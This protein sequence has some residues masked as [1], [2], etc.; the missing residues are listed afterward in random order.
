MS[1]IR[2]APNGEAGL[3][4]GEVAVLSSLVDA[5]NR[6]GFY[7]AYNAMFDSSEAS[8]QSRIAT[9]SG[10]VGGVAFAANRILQVVFGPGTN[11]DPEYTGIYHLSQK[12]A[13]SALAAI[14]SDLLSPSNTDGSADGY[15][16]DG[17]FFD[18]ATAA[19]HGLDTYF[20]GNLLLE[21]SATIA[22]NVAEFAGSYLAAIAGGATVDEALQ[23]SFSSLSSPGIVASLLAT[24]VYSNFG[25]T[26]S[27]LTAEGYTEI[28]GPNGHSLLINGD[29]IVGA[30]IGVDTNDALVVGAATAMETAIAAG[31]SIFALNALRDYLTTTIWPTPAGDIDP[32]HLSEFYTAGFNGDAQPFGDPTIQAGMPV[33]RAS[34]T[35]GADIISGTDSFLTIGGND[36]INGLG[37]NDLIFGYGGEDTIDGGAGNDIIWGQAGDDVLHG[38]EGDDLLRGGPGNNQLFGDAGNDV[39]YGGSGTDAFDGGDGWDAVSY[40]A[41]K[42]GVDIDLSLEI[43]RGGDAEGDTFVGIEEIRGSSF[44]DTLNGDRYLNKLVGG[45]GNDILISAPVRANLNFDGS[46]IYDPEHSN[47]DVLN[48]FFGGQDILDGGTGFDSYILNPPTEYYI[49]LGNPGQTFIQPSPLPN[50]AIV[51][52]EDGLGRLV[53]NDHN[54]TGVGQEFR[55]DWRQSSKLAVSAE[56]VGSDLHIYLPISTLFDYGD[57]EVF[58]HMSLDEWPYSPFYGREVPPE[59]AGVGPGTIAIKN[60]RDGDLGFY[61]DGGLVARADDPGEGL[62]NFRTNFAMSMASSFGESDPYGKAYDNLDGTADFNANLD[63]VTFT[64][65]GRDL[66]VVIDGSE[67]DPVHIRGAFDG[68]DYVRLGATTLTDLNFLDGTVSIADL[69]TIVASDRAATVGTSGNDVLT[70]HDGQADF[71]YGGLGSDTYVIT[72][73][74]GSDTIQRDGDTQAQSDTIHFDYASDR[75]FQRNNEQRD[76]WLR[77][78]RVEF[79]NEMTDGLGNT[80]LYLSEQQLTV[81][82]RRW[83]PVRE[84][85]IYD[86]TQ[87]YGYSF[88]DTTETF[89]DVQRLWVADIPY[90]LSEVTIQRTPGSYDNLTITHGDYTFTVQDHFLEMNDD[91]RPTHD[92]K[93]LFV[94]A[95]REVLTREM[96]A[97][98]APLV[99]DADHPFAHGT[100]YSETIIGST[101]KDWITAGPGDDVITGGLGD[102]HLE[103]DS[104]PMGENPREGSDTYVYNSGD[105]NDIIVDRDI[106]GSG[107]DKLVLADLNAGDVAL[108]KISL[109]VDDENWAPLEDRLNLVIVDKA[110]GERIEI[111]NQFAGNESGIE[112]IQFAD[113]TVFDRADILQIIANGY[114]GYNFAPMTVADDLYNWSGDVLTVTDAELLA[115]DV[116][117]EG[118]TL[119]VVSV[120]DAIGG[121]VSLNDGVVSFVRDSDYYGQGSFSYT[122]SDGEKQTTQHEVFEIFSNDPPRPGDTIGTADNDTLSGTQD[123]DRIYGLAGNDHIVALGGGDTLH[124]GS[125]NDIL[126]G[127]AGRDF[128]D[129]GPGSDWAVYDASSEGVAVDLAAGT[130]LVV[131]EM[132]PEQI[133]AHF[134]NQPPPPWVSVFMESSELTPD[135]IS[136]HELFGLGH[137]GDADWDELTSIENLGGSAFNDTLIG[138]AGDNVLRGND[139]NDTLDGRHGADVLEGGE[140]NDSYV[141][142]L[143]DGN[144]VITDNGNTQ[145]SDVL[146]LGAGI[147]SASVEFSRAGNNLVVTFTGGEHISITNQFAGAGIE[148]IAF[149]GGPT[150]ARADF[151]G[152]AGSQLWAANDDRFWTAANTPVV[153]DVTANDTIPDG[154]N[155]NAFVWTQAQHGNVYWNGSGYTYEPD[156]GF[157]GVDWFYYGLADADNDNQTMGDGAVAM[158]HVGQSYDPDNHTGVTEGVGTGTSNGN[159]FGGSSFN[160]TVNF[161]GGNQA[162][163]DGKGGDDIIVF[164]GNVSDYEIQG[165]GDHFVIHNTAT[166]DAVQFTNME[167]ISFNGTTAISLADIVANSN[168]NPG[169]VWYEPEPIGGLV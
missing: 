3:T 57:P 132:T 65:D 157:T 94:F 104:L 122:V 118:S 93:D 169:D 159:Y 1:E 147:S 112:L 151:E 160:D 162:Y 87:K 109:N 77:D 135:Q 66:W 76:L 32:A 99:M 117:V 142:N 14:R 48:R 161:T 29:G 58:H 16:N 25:K 38:G 89:T 63:D 145:D 137:G 120:Q 79:I 146:Q 116:D 85:S 111:L 45:A 108:A 107:V 139:G 96:I 69:A 47:P 105:G 8:L 24:L 72:A 42:Q 51:Y 152:L 136:S 115:N 124:G 86:L 13:E 138:G 123:G 19:W 91:M 128:L 28:S 22:A 75:V 103:G 126:E 71:F 26:A 54:L 52:D 7:M 88:T 127:G 41:S 34:P 61:F 60:Y 125:G 83:D 121:A 95:D 167:Y 106:E 5:H 84:T 92:F 49:V 40:E 102:D 166:D 140:G 70:G 101:A 68:G 27:A 153:V 82:D 130:R 131:S 129:G 133:E 78:Q 50:T 97:K 37:G 23:A 20:P 81:K 113:N 134:G 17:S 6:G 39:L 2:V 64:F 156:E 73:N 164:N 144:D 154:A 33:W 149:D 56:M 141:W 21:S 46:I 168:H 90:L 31:G 143:G 35:E 9:F 12:V 74:S 18:S 119:M 59:F 10:P 43:Q 163:A 44:N 62:Q 158:V 55:A 4:D 155:F 165:Q 110:T 30:V 148:S 53:Y 36:T 80:H 98:L 11:A 67:A 15:I 100:S 150:L 114:P